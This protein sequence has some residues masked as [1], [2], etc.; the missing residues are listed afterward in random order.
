VGAELRLGHLPA[1]WSTQRAGSG[2]FHLTTRFVG[3]KPGSNWLPGGGLSI[4]DF[5]PS[6][7]SDAGQAKGGG[8]RAV[9][10]VTHTHLDQWS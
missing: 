3:E 4:R 6:E 10:V 1:R 2:E 5:P 7:C 8:L 9:G